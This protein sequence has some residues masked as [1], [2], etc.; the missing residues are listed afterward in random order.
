MLYG[1]KIQSDI[2]LPE[3][4]SIEPETQVDVVVELCEP[5]QWVFERVRGGQVD[6]LEEQVMW[7][8]LKGLVLFYVENGNHIIIYRESELIS[9]IALRSYLTGS[10]M[11]LAI[12]Q[13]N[14]IPI[15]GGTVAWGGQAIIVSGVSGAGKS[16]ITMELYHQGF[17]FV[18]D[19]LSVVQV[20]EGEAQV[21]PGFPL[22]KV[23][24]DVVV[25]NNLNL[26]DLVYIDEDRDKFAR[27][28]KEGYETKPLPVLCMIELKVSDCLDSIEFEVVSGG[29]KF[30]QLTRNIYRG[31]VYQRLKN[32]PERFLRFVKATERI[33]MYR[34][35]RPKHGDFVEDIVEC[36][37][38]EILHING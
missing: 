4:V 38:R 33:Q 26:L 35:T 32:R 23:C 7:F 31:E 12:M 34:I 27:V 30:H 9:E 19:D 11:S 1:Q 8:Y 24:R 14:Y 29:D 18:A 25:K 6:Y 5:P 16:T 2:L 37:K 20:V 21:Y 36:I 22:Q 17:T 10:A 28:L 13:R 3:A 15:H